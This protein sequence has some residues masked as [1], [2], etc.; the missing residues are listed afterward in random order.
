[1]RGPLGT[2]PRARATIMSD[3]EP[4][5]V[6]TKEARRL[7]GNKSNASLYTAIARGELEAIK[8]GKKTLI[9]TRSIR[10]R[11]ENLPRAQIRGRS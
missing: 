6:P 2:Q 10:R 9:T 3:L 4:F 1:M 8:D 11:Q 7:L 5:A